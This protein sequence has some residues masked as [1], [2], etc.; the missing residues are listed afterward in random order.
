VGKHML[1]SRVT[2]QSGIF[3]IPF[4]EIILKLDNENSKQIDLVRT[5]PQ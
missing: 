2:D 4:R 1:C 3:S 5:P